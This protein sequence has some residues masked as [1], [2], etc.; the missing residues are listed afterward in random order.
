MKMLCRKTAS[1]FILVFLTIVS[2]IVQANPPFCA[3][4]F[5][6]GLQ[7]HTSDGTINFNYQAQLITSPDKQLE[8][9]HLKA[10]P[11]SNKKS[12]GL[13]DC[14]ATGGSSHQLYAP[15]PKTTNSTIEVNAHY[16][17]LILGETGN[18]FKKITVE[19]Q[20]G[21]EFLPGHDEYIIDRIDMKYRS[22]LRL[23]AGNYW[24]RSLNLDVQN[25][26]EIVGEGRVN[27]FVIDPLF[28]PLHNRINVAG[29]DASRFSIHA[30]SDI[31]FY[32]DSK[33]YGF[34][35]SDQQ[36]TLH[37][38]ST[39]TGGISASN[40]ELLSDSQVIFD[41]AAA[42]ALDFGNLCRSI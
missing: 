5:T 19:R 35:Y 33:V 39:I 7:T 30:Y 2:S 27:L 40:I 14:T 4:I 12:C 37:Y 16:P 22:Y 13:T 8:T 9:T 25:T 6:N 41:S 23:A 15:E 10:S 3:D 29:G 21:V 38:R 11:W 32:V 28:I 17:R 31:T 42:R 26:I 34:I 20:L 36:A 18:Q 24:I 1:F